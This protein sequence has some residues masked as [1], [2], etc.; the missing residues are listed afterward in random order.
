[1]TQDAKNADETRTV[2][3]LVVDAG[4]VE[5]AALS[6]EGLEDL[7]CERLRKTLKDLG[8]PVGG[9]KAN[10]VERLHLLYHPAE[11]PPPEAKDDAGQVEYAFP[12]KGRCPRCGVTDTIATSTQGDTQYR[13][14]RR[15][16]CRKTFAV[17]GNKI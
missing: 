8:E 2:V 9:T 6:R 11:D 7:S 14:C 12:T 17:K 10:L 4:D 13:Q 3:E 5:I 1:M 15:A 16:V